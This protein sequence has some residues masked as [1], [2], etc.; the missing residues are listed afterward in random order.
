M[1]FQPPTP[2][3]K[4]LGSALKA[5]CPSIVMIGSGPSPAGPRSTARSVVSLA[6]PNIARSCATIPLT[7]RP[8]Q[9]ATGQL[10]R[11]RA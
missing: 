10:R 6:F 3:V 11:R 9:T 4:T 5:H 2:S 1:P 8:E 7:V